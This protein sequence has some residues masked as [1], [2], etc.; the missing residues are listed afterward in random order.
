[1]LQPKPML[2]ACPYLQQ[3][4]YGASW[5]GRVSYPNPWPP[6][7]IVESNQILVE[8]RQAA[9]ARASSK[10]PKVRSRFNQD[11]S[12][13]SRFGQE[14]RKLTFLVSRSKLLLSIR[15]AFFFHF[16]GVQFYPSGRLR[17]CERSDSSSSCSRILAPVFS[18]L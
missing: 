5:Q 12:K 17:G 10:C 2:G 9:L 13:G 4:R 18:H 3:N 7:R 16:Y 1:M 6:M 14:T 8:K 15:L 11:H